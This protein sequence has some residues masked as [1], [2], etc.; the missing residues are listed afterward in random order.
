MSAG[1]RLARRVT[2]FLLAVALTIAC[3]HARADSL[4]F[5]FSNPSFSG[6]GYG[7]HVLTIENQEKSRK[8]ALEDERE[9]DLLAAER[10][11]ENSVEARFLRNLE[12]RIYSQLSRQLVDNL[13]GESPSTSGSF[14]LQGSVV[15]FEDTGTEVVLRIESPDGITELAIPTEQFLF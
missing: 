10:D 1:P 6:V 5:G 12:S 14:E 9:A 4:V 11:A 15:S 3:F 13:F 8:D 7:S 2:E